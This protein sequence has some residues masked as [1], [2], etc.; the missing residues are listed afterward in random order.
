MRWDSLW[1]GLLALLRGSTEHTAPDRWQR[2][3]ERCKHWAGT[4][5]QQMELRREG[6]LASRREK[7]KGGSGEAREEEVHRKHLL[8]G[9]GLRV[10]AGGR[11]GAAR[12]HRCQDPVALASLLPRVT[13]AARGPAVEG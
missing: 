3:W 7:R 13:G 5:L 11:S 1:K 12:V 4:D 9:R 6:P 2:Q 10:E 8:R